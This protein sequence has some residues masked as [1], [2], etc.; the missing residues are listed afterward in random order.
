MRRVHV[1]QVIYGQMQSVGGICLACRIDLLFELLFQATLHIQLNRNNAA[2]VPASTH[3]EER[4]ICALLTM[5]H[6][7]PPFGPS[8]RWPAAAGDLLRD[9]AHQTERA[10]FRH[11][12]AVRYASRN[13]R[14]SEASASN[15]ARTILP[16]PGMED[17]IS[18]SRCRCIACGSSC[19]RKDLSYSSISR[20]I[21]R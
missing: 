11:S 19:S 5:G 14:T 6:V 2:C 3:W 9:A 1:C 17:K 10:V 7:G 8:G 21:S 4:C 13:S 20:S 16:T 15:V 18:T 12:P